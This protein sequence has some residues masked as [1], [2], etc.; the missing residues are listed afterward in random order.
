LPLAPRKKRRKA[1]RRGPNSASCLSELSLD[2]QKPEGYTARREPNNSAAAE[3]ANRSRKV[4][5]IP[6]G[7]QRHKTPL[8]EP[9][10]V[11]E[12]LLPFVRD[13]RN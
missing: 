8:I 11:P 13:H 6:P 10:V 12:S 5:G 7:R 2:E 1:T 4:D 9:E 3:T